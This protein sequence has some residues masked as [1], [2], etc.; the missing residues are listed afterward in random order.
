M[1]K[2]SARYIFEDPPSQP[3][4]YYG[5][6]G[7]DEE[8]PATVGKRRTNIPMQPAKTELP[9]LVFLHGFAGSADDWSVIMEYGAGQFESYA[10]NLPGH[11]GSVNLDD[12]DAYTFTGAVHVVVESIQEVAIGPVHLVGYSMGGRLAIYAALQK[13]T[14][15]VSL[16]VESST[17]GLRDPQEREQRIRTDAELSKRI[18]EMPLEDFF[19]EWYTQ[20]F[21]ASFS[22][23]QREKIVSARKRNDAMEL[24]KSLKG[25]SVGAQPS[26]WDRLSELEIPTT[27]ISGARDE[28][29]ANLAIQMAGLCKRGQSAIVPN[30]GHN[31]HVEQPD[32]FFRC[33]EKHLALNAAG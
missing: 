7:E 1:W 2:A 15:F 9:M 13:P 33:I 18:L 3:S 31:V 24:A 11:G 4:A 6:A 32:A 17:A 5:T 21:F 10:I 8:D 25:L 22:D 29:Y 19:R 27:F 23:E 20:P 16:L 30:A 26:L 28:K 12:S 14:L